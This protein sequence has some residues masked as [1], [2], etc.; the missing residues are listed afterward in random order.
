MFGL[1]DPEP[2]VA[3]FFTILLTTWLVWKVWLPIL[4]TTT[5]VDDLVFT[6]FVGPYIEVE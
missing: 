1:K 6:N 3:E 5:E 4:G 2:L